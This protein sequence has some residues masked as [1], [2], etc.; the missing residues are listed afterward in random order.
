MDMEYS[1]Q[2]SRPPKSKQTNKQSRNTGRAL[3]AAINR[4]N[5]NHLPMILLRNNR[6]LDL[7]KILE[8]KVRKY[9][10]LDHYDITKK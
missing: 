9:E 3:A 6:E 5:E 10:L 8:E 4:G 1:C 7:G 2:I